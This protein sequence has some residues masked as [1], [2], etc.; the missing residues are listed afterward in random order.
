M[1]VISNVAKHVE[2][3]DYEHLRQGFNSPRVHPFSDLRRVTS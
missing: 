1:T 3:L 2:V